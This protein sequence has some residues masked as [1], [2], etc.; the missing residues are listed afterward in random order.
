MTKITF[1]AALLACF[2]LTSAA[3]AED[4]KV[5]PKHTKA[6]VTCH[7]CHREEHPTK[8]AVADESCMA[9]HGDLPAMA[10]YTKALPVNPHAVPKN[11]HPGPWACTECHHQHKAAVV[12]CLECHPGFKLTP[13]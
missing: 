8:G 11:G 4:P 13:R 1:A 5:P 10:A 7:D 9:C 12:K 2:F 6:G 3:R